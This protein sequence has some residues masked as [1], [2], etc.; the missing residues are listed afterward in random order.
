MSYNSKY[1]GAEVEAKLEKIDSL[2]AGMEDTDETV[3]DVVALSGATPVIDHGTEDTTFELTPNVI[4]KWGI[5]SS[6]TL[7][8]PNDEEGKANQYKVVFTANSES[9]TL[10]LPNT[11]SWAGLEAPTFEAL[12]TYEL[13]IEDGRIAYDTFEYCGRLD[14][15]ENDATDYDYIV[16]DIVP[17][18]GDTGAEVIGTLYAPQNTAAGLCGA[19]NDLS[20]TDLAC[21][22]LTAGT[23]CID[24]NGT[25]HEKGSYIKGTKYIFSHTGET[26]TQQYGQ[27]IH[28][29]NVNGY[30]SVLG[31]M[32]IYS[33]KIFGADGNARV[34]LL[35]YRIN[36]EV[37][38]YDVINK[39]FYTGVAGKL[40][41]GYDE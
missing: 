3:E 22:F 4:H 30:S 7:T 1:K 36:G 34:E 21:F 27:P 33:L 32:R 2:N 28:I 15:I 14:W 17:Q 41:G 38:L 18:T 8:V 13:N 31:H 23:Y 16:T 40:T 26:L 9:F 29:F 19:R 10:S 5:V 35:P 25:R 20:T 39:K 6:L 12:I 37:G 24:W 11:L